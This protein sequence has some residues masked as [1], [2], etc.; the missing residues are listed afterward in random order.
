MYK[1]KINDKI[2]DYE[3]SEFH[4]SSRI[5]SET[6]QRKIS[7]EVAIELSATQTFVDEIEPYLNMP[8]LNISILKND[9]EIL[10]FNRYTKIEEINTQ[11]ISEAYAL[12]GS[13]NRN[14]GKIKSFIVFS[15]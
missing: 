10:S 15:K 1:L 2:F 6:M 9:E 13:P 8:T 5:D 4:E 7:L 3:I 12:P 14:D 11:Y